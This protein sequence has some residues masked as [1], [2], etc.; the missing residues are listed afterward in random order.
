MAPEIFTVKTTKNTY[1]CRCDM[2][3]VGVVMYALVTGCLPFDE[4]TTPDVEAKVLKGDYSLDEGKC[5]ERSPSLKV[6]VSQLLKVDPRERM[7][8]DQAVECKWMGLDSE[9]LSV[10]D[11]SVSKERMSVL[12][13]SLR[14]EKKTMRRVVTAVS[15]R[16][17]I[18]HKKS[19]IILT[20]CPYR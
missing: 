5:G 16:F 3:S 14:K 11:L 1:D 2:W 8:A 7:T 15:C 12:R 9:E 10:C 20:V 4:K 18:V 19:H 17:Q 13:D 6:M